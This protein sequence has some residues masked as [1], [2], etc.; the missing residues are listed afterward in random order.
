MPKF[1][2][3]SGKKFGRLNVITGVRKK[4]GWMW[5]C[6]CDC[7]RETLI[8]GRS[9]TRSKKPTRSCGCL[10]SELARG[11]VENLSATYKHGHAVGGR[12]SGTLQTWGNMISRCT[13]PND[14]NWIEYGGRGISV[15]TRWKVFENFLVDM[16]TRP[17]NS[18]IERIDNNGNYELSNCR[19]ATQKEQ[20][21]NRRNT[22]YVNFNNKTLP[23]SSWCELLDVNYQI[24]YDHVV[25]YGRDFEELLK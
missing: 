11:R 17:D 6:I 23:L 21:R 16:G 14:K 2:D 15:C 24:A 20:T 13:R 3:L 1:N 5:K 25:R 19:W 10:A 7:G 12:R 8:E 18:S 22:I 4:S 9:L